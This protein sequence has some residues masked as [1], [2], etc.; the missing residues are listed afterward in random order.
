MILHYFFTF[1][2]K[3]SEIL[4]LSLC[5]QFSLYCKL[6]VVAYKTKPLRTIY[7]ANIQLLQQIPGETFELHF[8]VWLQY[9]HFGVVYPLNLIAQVDLDLRLSLFTC[10]HGFLS[11]QVPFD[12]CDIFLSLLWDN[13]YLMRKGMLVII[14]ATLFS[15]VWAS[16]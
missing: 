7:S 16:L 1:I 5:L 8:L 2:A 4:S 14:T 12:S 15:I 6:I 3:Q 13:N 11:E 9:F 10:W